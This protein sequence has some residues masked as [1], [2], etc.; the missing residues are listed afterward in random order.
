M[1]ICKN[2]K[3]FVCQGNE[4]WYN[5]TCHHDQVK[6]ITTIDPTFGKKA[7]MIK[8][9]LGQTVFVEEPYPN[10]REINPEGECEFF[11]KK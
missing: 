8:N 7:Y 2:C 6:R 4:I 5:A 1:N 9:G 3:Y 10:C 11:N